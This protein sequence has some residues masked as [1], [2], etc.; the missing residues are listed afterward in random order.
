M[1]LKAVKK[2]VLLLLPALFPA[3]NAHAG[4]FDSF[5]SAGKDKYVHFCA[6]TLISHGSYP[7]FRG[8]LK[9]KESAWLYSL[10]LAVLASAGK[11]LSDSRT[12][13]FSGSDMLAGIAG[14]ATIVVVRF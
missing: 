8:Y 4:A 5:S 12:T 14:G 11:E 6:G 7:L 13:G 10:G 2:T 1:T 3:A 9:N